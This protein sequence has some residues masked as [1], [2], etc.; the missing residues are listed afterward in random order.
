MSWTIMVTFLCLVRASDLP[1]INIQNL[2]KIIHST[3]HFVFTVLWFLFFR[4]QINSPNNTK[5]LVISFLLS[6]LFGIVIEILQGLTTTTRQSDILDV[7]ANVLG[8][9]LAVLVLIL[10]NKYHKLDKI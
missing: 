4:K 1:V 10:L 8:A 3:F 2:D 5:P 9:T 6:V 7:L